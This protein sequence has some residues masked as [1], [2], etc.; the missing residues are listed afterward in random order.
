MMNRRQFVDQYSVPLLVS[1][2][3][4]A[5]WWVVTEDPI[6]GIATLVATLVLTTVL[7][8]ATPFFARV[9]QFSN[10]EVR[11][12]YRNQSAADGDILREL[13]G[14]QQIDILTV[15]GLG[16]LGLNDS[17]LRK[18]VMKSG[19]RKLRIRVLL[20]SPESSDVAARARE[21]GES[22]DAFK[23]GIHLALERLRELKDSSAHDLEVYLYETLPCWRI[24]AFDTSIFVSVFG[25]H[26]EGHR[27]TMY[28]IDSSKK[29]TLA[30]GYRRMFDTMCSPS[31][32]VI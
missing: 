19:D 16:I 4:S 22:D 1:L 25:Q 28:R 23:H 27:A 30:L 12:I 13:E 3:S 14:T 15:R 20:L 24:I 10:S 18:P 8:R 29:D 11:R 2:I 6:L 31:R 5:I 7:W 26:V 17:L 21:I 32:R 9:Q